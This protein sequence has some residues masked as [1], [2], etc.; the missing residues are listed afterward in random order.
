MRYAGDQMTWEQAMPQ[1]LIRINDV[2]AARDELRREV[3]RLGVKGKR[4]TKILYPP[5][6]ALR[7]G[8]A[9]FGDRAKYDGHPAM[10][11][12]VVPY[13]IIIEHEG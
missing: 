6:L 9:E 8:V 11:H 3:E 13:E 5:S 4:I 1:I 7:L 12:K 2:S 10:P